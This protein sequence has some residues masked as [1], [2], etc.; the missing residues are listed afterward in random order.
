MIDFT[1]CD[2]EPLR[3]YDGANGKKIC[4]IY[5]NERY[6]LKF[7]ALARNNPVMHYSNG[8]LNEHIASYNY[9][10]NNIRDLQ[11]KNGSCLQRFL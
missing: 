9:T 7:P 3:V 2:V 6:M 10:G 4:V 5:N 8:C 11:W 1:Q